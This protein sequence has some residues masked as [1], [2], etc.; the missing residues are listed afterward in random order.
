MG[1][2]HAS[3][4]CATPQDPVDIYLQ[5]CRVA[6]VAVVVEVDQPEVVQVG[7]LADGDPKPQPRH[8]AARSHAA[9]SAS[10]AR[11]V[12]PA[13]HVADGAGVLQLAPR[14]LV[15]RSG[16]DSSFVGLS[17]VPS[18][19]LLETTAAAFGFQTTRVR[20]APHPTHD[21][22]VRTYTGVRR[23]QATPRR[24]FLR[25]ERPAGARVVRGMPRSLEAAVTSG[26]GAVHLWS[27]PVSWWAFSGAGA[28][29]AR[30]AALPDEDVPAEP[31]IPVREAAAAPRDP[32]AGSGMLPTGM[33]PP[34]RGTWSFDGEVASRFEH[35]ARTHI[36]DYVE[37]VD[38][39]VRAAEVC[40]AA[41]GLD[42]TCHSVIDVGCA[43]GHTMLVL[44]KR[45]TYRAV[46]GV[47]SAPAMAARCRANLTAAG[48]APVAE[49]CVHEA[50]S[51]PAARLLDQPL[52][53][54]FANW[55]L[56]FIPSAVQREAYLRSVLDALVP[57]GVL[58]LTEKTRQDAATRALYHEWK[59][60]RG[61][62]AAEIRLKAAAL[63]GV[64]V[65]LPADWYV[66][67]LERCGFVNVTVLQARFAFITWIASK[68]LSSASTA[69]AHAPGGCGFAAAAIDWLCWPDFARTVANGDDDAG[70]RVAATVAYDGMHEPAPFAFAAWGAGIESW[71]NE[72]EHLSVHGYVTEGPATLERLGEIRF[73]CTL[74]AGCYFACPGGCELRGGAGVVALA[75]DGRAGVHRA[76]F[77]VGGPVMAGPGR[78]PYIDGC[79]DTLLLSPVRLGAPCLNHLHF[80]P[81]I[82]QTRHTH[83]SGRAGVVIAG[84]G[85]CVLDAS[86]SDG[87]PRRVQ[88]RPGT[89]F[90]IPEGL[91]H[92]FETTEGSELD[93]IA[94]H[95][96]SDFGPAPQNHPMINRTVV[97]GV[98]ASR[99]DGIRTA[100]LV[101]PLV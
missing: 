11:G 93:V 29:A 30:S 16:E 22:D 24:F 91:P 83:P 60:E 77:T 94:F 49:R 89:A 63:E 84:Q 23:F 85:V 73:E 4:A 48:H 8:T 15:N 10:L 70:A 76:L 26:S 74:M 13:P 18:R 87:E 45:A 86:S 37:V 97:D 80:P 101:T 95:P 32:E 21:A 3:K 25:C 54:V 34:T 6:A 31:G 52:G 28:G 14:A 99:L 53:A 82:K 5:M 65:P 40:L 61:V 7:I 42:P 96:D 43:T 67:A 68:P 71:S 79:T 2:T 81:A 44:L 12:A 59:G 90:V 58:V 47:D 39:S 35:E 55:T 72:D 36:P 50:V 38:L 56:H 98:S 17:V 41:S 20:L 75:P 19:T 62:S 78:L 64:L 100:D 46:H 66:G 57:G 88:L 33:P 69:S 27:K 51:L 1:F 92:A 9:G